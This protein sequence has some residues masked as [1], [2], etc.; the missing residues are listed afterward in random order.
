MLMRDSFNNSNRPF[1]FE[2]MWTSHPSFPSIINE[3]F[4]NNSPLI[5][6]TETFKSLVTH[7][8]RHTFGNI[9]HKK[10]RN[11]ARIA[12]IQKLP[13][14]QFNNYLLNLESN[15][16]RELDSIFKN[17]DDFWKLKSRFNWL[18]EGDANIRFFH[19]STLN[20]RRRN[21]IMSLKEES[22]N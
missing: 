19:T 4:T 21:M 7:W 13:N 1:R 16:I 9:F 10:R 18:T 3:T 22:G 8:K 5:Q 14:Y 6:S 11:M 17:E 12:G 2:S 15:L 20:W